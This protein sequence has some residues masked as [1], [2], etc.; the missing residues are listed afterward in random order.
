MNRFVWLGLVV[1]VVVG[2]WT[3][4]WFYIA[5]EAR[6]AVAGLAAGDGEAAPKLTC[7]SLEMTG[8]PFRFDLTCMGATIVDGDVNVAIAG[9]KGSV[10]AYNPTHALLSAQG[11]VTIADAF[12]GGQSRVDFSGAEASIRLQSADLWAGLQ[13]AGWRIARA[14]LVADE[15]RWTDTL[16]GESLIG[17]ASRLEAH[18]LDIP[19]QHEPEKGLAALAAYAR[20]DEVQAPGFQIAGGEA[21][22]EAELSGL[23]DDLRALGTPDVLQRWR[24]AG[25]QLKL[26]GLQGTAGEEF[27]RSTGTLGLDSSARVEGRIELAS[28]GLIERTGTLVPEDWKGLVLGAPAADGSY[29]QTLSLRGGFVFAGLMPVGQLAPLF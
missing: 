14:S 25:G 17:S 9:L 20:L 10:L 26:V 6:N 18:L 11:P 27:V 21:S 15:L 8:F 19:E 3:A 24:D 23:P 12:T 5:G 2:A 13:G 16:T 4:G 7:A 22:L 28:K 1:L 29:S